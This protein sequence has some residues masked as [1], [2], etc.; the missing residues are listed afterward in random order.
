MST[1]KQVIIIVLP[2]ILF[3][4]GCSP[5]KDTSETKYIMGVVVVVG[6]EPFTNLAIQTSPSDVV[7]LD[8]DKETKD[9]LLNNQG[10]KVKIFY[11]KI[12][13]TKKPNIIYLQKSE[14]IPEEKQ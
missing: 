3:I 9:Y 13:N 2:V 10:K 5:A 8:C 4:Y 6:N 7:I 12:D 1:I 14:I 11:E